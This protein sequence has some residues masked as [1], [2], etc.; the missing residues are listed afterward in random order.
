LLLDVSF[1][2]KEKNERVVHIYDAME[3]LIEI[4]ERREQSL[5]NI[6]DKY[7]QY[8]ELYTKYNFIQ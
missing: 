2:R 8:D 6:I 4:A 3:E 5:E 7:V 1:R